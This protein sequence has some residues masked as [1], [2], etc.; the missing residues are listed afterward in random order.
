MIKHPG[1]VLENVLVKVDKFIFPVDF[2]VLDME[3][4][5]EIPIILGRPFLATRGALIDVKNGKLTLTIQD[6]KI[7]FDIFKIVYLRDRSDTCL[8]ID[9]MTNHEKDIVGNPCSYPPPTTSKANSSFSL[10]MVVHDQ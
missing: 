9:S 7:S 6:E 4:D 5:Q 3:E 10:K 2:I 8:N 1:G